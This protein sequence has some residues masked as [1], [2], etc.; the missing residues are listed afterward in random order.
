MR[1]Y[2]A[3]PQLALHRPLGVEPPDRP[4]MGVWQLT[5]DLPFTLELTFVGGASTVGM[6]KTVAS[7][8]FHRKHLANQ[9]VP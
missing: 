7:P 8:A 2:L 4:N 3:N 9:R 5:A 1:I 6:F